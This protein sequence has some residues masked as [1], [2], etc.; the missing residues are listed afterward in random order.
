MTYDHRVASA[1]EALW[2]K[3]EE[4][5]EAHPVWTLAGHSP[6]FVFDRT[7]VDAR[8]WVRKYGKGKPRE[9]LGKGSTAEAAAN[10]LIE[11][12]DFWVDH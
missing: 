12:L 8:V 10:S 2:R 3:I 6:S 11:M 4:A 1:Y 5:I 9:L 7:G